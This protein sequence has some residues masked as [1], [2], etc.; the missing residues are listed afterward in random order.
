MEMWKQARGYVPVSVCGDRPGV[1][2]HM[3]G[4]TQAPLSSTNSITELDSQLTGVQLGSLTCLGPQIIRIIQNSHVY[5][6][7]F[8]H[9]YKYC[10]I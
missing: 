3:K 7:H 9:T 4:G 2:F 1:T 10:S 6:N 5:G 8:L